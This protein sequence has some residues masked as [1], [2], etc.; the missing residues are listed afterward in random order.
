ML[1]LLLIFQR[2]RF[3]SETQAD[4]AEYSSF[5]G[6]LLPEGQFKIA[7]AVANYR[8]KKSRK[9]SRPIWTLLW[10][11]TNPFFNICQKLR[12]EKS[13]LS[14]VLPWISAQSVWRWPH[15]RQFPLVPTSATVMI[16]TQ[17]SLGYGPLLSWIPTVSKYALRKEVVKTGW[18]LYFVRDG[19]RLWICHTL[20]WRTLNLND[21]HGSIW[22]GPSRPRTYRYR[23]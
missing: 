6:V 8:L 20:L 17:M 19:R 23:K 16:I 4:C 10:L 22:N 12:R 7:V 9:R 11:S 13:G 14:A 2:V 1:Y 5:S 18:R 15:F 21:E 3:Q